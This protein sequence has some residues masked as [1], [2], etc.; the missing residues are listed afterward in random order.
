MVKPEREG[1]LADYVA[2]YSGKFRERP[3]ISCDRCAT[4]TLSYDNDIRRWTR[5]GP[6]GAPPYLCIDCARH[7]GL[8][9]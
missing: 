2:A 5:S 6:T 1:L 9:W 7:Y 4:F 3:S 8:V